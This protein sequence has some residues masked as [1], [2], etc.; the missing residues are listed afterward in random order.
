MMARA[1]GIRSAKEIGFY[2]GRTERLVADYLELLKEAEKVPE[3]R[4]RL[5]SLKYQMRH[6]ERKSPG[7]RGFLLWSGGPCHVKPR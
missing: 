6:L 4:E 7:K 1:R 5:E 2:L 3:E